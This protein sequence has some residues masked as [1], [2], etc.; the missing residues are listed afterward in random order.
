M[1][2][3]KISEVYWRLDQTKEGNVGQVELTAV[4]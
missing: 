1:A 3:L 4:G 2:F